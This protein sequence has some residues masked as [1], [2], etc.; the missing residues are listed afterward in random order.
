MKLHCFICATVVF[1][2]DSAADLQHHS[3]FLHAQVTA[4]QKTGGLYGCSV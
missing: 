1:P 2:N 3:Y 4:L